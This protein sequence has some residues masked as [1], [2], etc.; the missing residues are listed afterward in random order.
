MLE[1]AV[2]GADR[3]RMLERRA[4]LSALNFDQALNLVAARLRT[5]PELQGQHPIKKSDINDLFE[6]GRPVRGAQSDCALPGSF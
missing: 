6:A 2:R 1:T 3:D 5:I 4:G